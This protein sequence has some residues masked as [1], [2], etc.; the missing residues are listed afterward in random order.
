M[1][2][3]KKLGILI[4]GCGAREHSLALRLSRE[5]AV[6]K[7]VVVPGNAGIKGPKLLKALDEKPLDPANGF[8]DLLSWA[9]NMKFGLVIPGDQKYVLDGLG[10]LFIKGK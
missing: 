1:D 5:D 3:E 4:L 6:D 10:E 9:T 8:K 7:V 2:E